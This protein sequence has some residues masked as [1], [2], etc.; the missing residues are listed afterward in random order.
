MKTILATLALL[1][2]TNLTFSQSGKLDV[3]NMNVKF[4]ASNILFQSIAPDTN[5]NSIS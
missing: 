5:S 2:Y 3:N 1:L 4:H